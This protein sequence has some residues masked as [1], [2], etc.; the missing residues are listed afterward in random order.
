M[1]A[2]PTDNLTPMIRQYLEIKEQHKDAFLF[3]RM[4]DFYEMFFDDAVNAS[5]ILD[6]AL[7]ARN[8]NEPNPIPF[9]GVPHHSAS[10]YIARLIEKGYKVAICEQTEDPALAKGLVKREVVQIITPGLATDL[11]AL[12]KN[13]KNYIS[14][15]QWD[16]KS[17]ALA[18][19]DLLT[20]EFKYS[21]LVK[22]EE[23]FDLY[24]LITPQ[25]ILYPDS[26]KNLPLFV[27]LKERFPKTLFVPLSGWVLDAVYGEK[28][29]KEQFQTTSLAA[30]G[31]EESPQVIGTLGAILHYVR[32]HQ[33]MTRIP[34]L[35]KLEQ[36]EKDSFL[37]IGE[38]TRRNLEIDL[39]SDVLD[40]TLTPMGGRLLR[41]W[42]RR[43]QIDIQVINH[44]LDAVGELQQKGRELAAI[45]KSLTS[46]C[47]IE[48]VAGKVSLK[49]V[50]ARELV[51]LKDS[52]EVLKQLG[53]NLANFT[54]PLLKG[55]LEKWDPLST[56]VAEI[57]RTLVDEPPLSLK[58]GGLI[59]VGFSSELDELRDII[60]GGK[61]SVLA[62]EERER[63]RTGINSLKVRFNKVFGY[64]IEITN[65]HLDKIPTDYIRKQTLVNAERFITPELKEYEGKVLSAEERIKNLEY[66]LFL[67]LRERLAPL[68]SQIQEQACRVGLL[69]LLSSL[70][71]V[72]TTYRYVRPKLTMG[73]E[74]VITQGRHPVIERLSSRQA[75][76]PNDTLLDGEENRFLIITGPNM[77]G[78][79]TI[80]RQTAL[81]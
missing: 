70:A 26:I 81:I 69:D 49:N 21:R 42:L 68:A 62:M 63:S 48:R 50:S 23:L 67:E 24:S 3:F 71:K 46:I 66:E 7:T 51:M 77:A 19:F 58:D 80:M 47:D 37:W 53:E 18:F 15:F 43:P 78:K 32:E 38:E 57:G 8:K 64:Y 1:T 31:L 72:A 56:V 28:L 75:F 41:E 35:K 54:S 34:H 76:F 16:G 40:L 36:Y 33:K 73:K 6:I 12:P 52:C 27:L 39:L 22:Q 44:R 2:T 9:C 55:I 20:G 4:G 61:S 30:F 5:K 60:H 79:S 10:S 29:V 11:E 13:E 14:C 25:E 74:L 17:G 59:R 45:G 65:S